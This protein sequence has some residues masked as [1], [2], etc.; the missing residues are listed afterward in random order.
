MKKYIVLTALALVLNAAS[1]ARAEAPGAIQKTETAVERAAQA[2]GWE[3]APQAAPSAPAADIM[4]PTDEAAAAAPKPAADSK[5]LPAGL[6]MNG[7]STLDGPG[8]AAYKKKQR[9]KKKAAAP[10]PAVE[11]AAPAAVEAAPPA[12]AFAPTPVEAPV[13]APE[14]PAPAPE[15]T[16]PAPA[17][18]PEMPAP[19]AAPQLEMPAPT[20]PGAP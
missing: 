18:A 8:T 16:A 6:V 20:I 4:M 1:A 7:P 19:E 5:K 13:P 12:E 2:M 17:P 11:A 15:I 14:V 9:K 10:K 3:P